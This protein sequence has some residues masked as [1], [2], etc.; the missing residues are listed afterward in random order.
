MKDLLA[1]KKIKSILIELDR[2]FSEHIE[3]ISVLK[4]F[5]YK[6]LYYNDKDGVSNHIFD[7]N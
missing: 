5:D 1:S 7:L 6:L 4:S 2:T 3:V